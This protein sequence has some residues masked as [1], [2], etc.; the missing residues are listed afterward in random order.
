MAYWIVAKVTPHHE[1]LAVCS[2]VTLGYEIF[3]PRVRVRVG[4]RWKTTWAFPSYFF[5]RRCA[6]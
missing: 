5:V 6:S 3:V 1:Q 4:M 2:V